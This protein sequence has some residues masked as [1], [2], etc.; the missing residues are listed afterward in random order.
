MTMPYNETETGI[1]D[2]GN[3][4]DMND[5]NPRVG[6][7]AEAFREFRTGESGLSRDD[8]TA[9]IAEYGENRLPEREPDGV[10]RIFLS[11][12]RS[13]LILIL[14]VACA[15]VFATGETTDGIIILVVLFFNAV[16]GTVQEGRA[17]DTL[18]ALRR[19]AETNATV[20]RDGR[21]TIIPDTEVVPGDVV[22]LQEGEKIPADALLLVSHSLKVDESS[23][24]GESEPVHKVES[25]PDDGVG[26]EAERRYAVFRGTHVV[27]GSGKA[28]V[29]AT[30]LRSRIGGIAERIASIDSDIPL[31]R[32]IAK[33]SNVIILGV[34]L[35]SIGLFAVGV[36]TGRGITLMVSTAVTL[37]VSV[38]P[39]GLPIVV[40]LV[41]A[42]GVSRMSRRNALVKKLHAVE[43]LGAARVIAVDK[44]GTITKNELLV[45]QAYLPATAAGEDGLSCSI[46]GSGYEPTG[47]V[48]CLGKTVEPANH[49]RLT[50]LGKVATLCSGA[51]V[52]LDGESGRYRV[53]GDPTEAAMSVFA[54]K[55]GFHRETLF[56]ETEIVSEFPFDY[57]RKIH[58][59]S[60]READDIRLAVTGA[61]EA[62]IGRSAGIGPGEWR[63]PMTPRDREVLM[64]EFVRMS[65]EGLRV[66]ALAERDRGSESLGPDEIRE[67]SFVGFL[68]MKDDLRPEVP[69]AMRRAAEAGIRVV[70]ITGD[71]RTTAETIAAEAGIFHPGDRVLTG[72]DIDTFS[73]ERLAASLD[74]TTV[75]ARVN[76]EHKLRIIEAYKA[77][78][79]IVAMTG[80]GVNDAPS[81]VAA[82]LGV[83]M[84][85]IGTEVAKEAAD[86]VLLDDNFGS[87]I[88]AVEE[89][90]SIYLS[91][92][93]VVLY[94]FSTGMGEVATIIGAMAVGLPIPIL[95]AQIIWLN[96]VTDGF[97]DV[98][99]GMEPKEAGLLSGA[100]G[101]NRRIL[102][103]TTV[104]R[105]FLMGI[106]MAVGTI[107]VFRGY[108]SVDKAKALTVS[109]S[110]LAVFQWVNA[111]NCRNESASVFRT[112]PFSNRFLVLALLAVVALQSL[113]VYHP[114]FQRMLHTVPL[115]FADWGVI[116]G[117]SFLILLAEESR[118][119]V[120]RIFGKSGASRTV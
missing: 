102:D 35:I 59:V 76:P 61:P 33:M 14:L 82:D 47:E 89:G 119:A 44:T 63:R 66:V 86:I 70:M 105:M 32:E 69:S 48:K 51:R 68:G 99:L 79:E 26:T 72:A 46:G 118:K 77:R 13:P 94:L 116:L 17:Q 106:V 108:L 92:R 27:S 30:G 7:I 28:V 49:P 65:R 57:I 12:F 31:R 53:A 36:A 109:F 78:G 1:N 111:W 114:F 62:V 19:Y 39:E 25:G 90:R 56:S 84:G 67:L 15:T 97:L 113:A 83:A 6:P 75:F 3:E 98:S 52:A 45:E 60:Y 103:A 95:P 37:A 50:A 58:A 4:T 22:L 117:V 9:R 101:R 107:A 21:E 11:Q 40:T 16:V 81:L 96:L 100:S 85:K 64:T 71:F 110:I 73:D 55:V 20:L 93:K 42:A 41:L 54:G 88:S 74:R 18:L 104:F 29:T 80:D 120:V 115:S 24:S 112:N 87:I 2:M 38:I 34:F 91:I 5:K 8:A 43:T 10:V 23:L